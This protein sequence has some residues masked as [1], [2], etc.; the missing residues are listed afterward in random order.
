MHFVFCWLFYLLD[1]KQVQLEMQIK[2][3]INVCVFISLKISL[4]SKYGDA[5]CDFF[6]FGSPCAAQLI[7]Y[8]SDKYFLLIWLLL[9][10][11]LQLIY[12]FMP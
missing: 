4:M 2:T 8:L 7:Y 6:M 5:V 10:S 3:A 12:H 1:K 11:V 9:F